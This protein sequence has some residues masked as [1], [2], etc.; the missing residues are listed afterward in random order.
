MAGSPSPVPERWLAHIADAK[1]FLSGP[2]FVREALLTVFPVA[3]LEPAGEASPDALALE[4][5]SAESGRLRVRLAGQ[6]IL[7]LESAAHLAPLLETSLFPHVL[8]RNP[9]RI[10]LHA[11][12]VEWRGNVLLLPG[13]KGSGKS[14][15]SLGLSCRG[16]EYLSDELTWLLP[17]RCEVVPFPKAAT[18]KAGSFD[19]FAPAPEHPD[20]ARGA[21]RY[22]LPKVHADASDAPRPVRAILFPC[23]NAGAHFEA[24]PLHPE[25]TAL[26][27]VQFCYGGLVRHPDSVATLARLSARPAWALVYGA[28][29]PVVEFLI[30]REANGYGA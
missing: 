24:I 21:L 14:T 2:S 8:R 20:P 4:V 25:E 11:A 7:H 10:A 26:G 6:P 29:D 5:E 30:E 13:G 23:F 28:I 22:I 27:L 12:A 19:L 16:A 9:D 3:V 1:V 17:N 15:L 18:V